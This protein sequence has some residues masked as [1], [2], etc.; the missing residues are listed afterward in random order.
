MKTPV[1]L[2]VFLVILVSLSFC[3]D[4]AASQ[5]LEIYFLDMFGGGSTLIV[6]PLNES[7]LIDTGSREPLHRDAD[8]ILQV[9][10]IAEIKQIDFLITTH[11][12]SDH[13]GGILEV[14]KRIPIRRFIDKGAL[15]SKEEQTSEWFRQ[16]YPLYKEATKEKVI[17]IHA[18]EDIQLKKDPSRKIPPVILHCIASEKQ[19]EGFQGI[20]DREIEGFEM[21]PADETDNA[22][23]IAL[24]LMFGRF[25]FLAGADITWNIEHHLVHPV[26]RIG[27]IDL[28]QINHH[29]LDQSNNPLFL[30]AIDPIV[31]VALN[32]P[33][34]GIQPNTF[35]A[36]QQLPNV[37]AIYQI[38]Y[39]VL[40]GDT[41]NAPAE[42]IANREDPN[43]GEFIK[44][45]VE[46]D[47][48]FFTVTIGTHGVK[49]S[50]P[51]R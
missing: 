7:I 27:K 46:P 44:V 40:Y 12:H 17:P 10:H 28:Y 11:F 30:K 15:P 49:K 23:S 45:M 14:S 43:K 18:G 9:C 31:C 39:N 2:S 19:I 34:K 21:K 33:Y 24:L 47:T 16:L 48:R 26:N 8:R 51:I 29:G 6:T 32:G 35:R 20:I 1:L 5:A 50:Y 42:F 4:E 13:F 38:H 37:E 3:N 25:R 36:L 22:R 41:G